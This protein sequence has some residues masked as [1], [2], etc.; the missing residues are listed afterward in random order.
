MDFIYFVMS[1]QETAVFGVPSNSSL[2]PRPLHHGLESR[3]FSMYKL[4]ITIVKTSSIFNSFTAP[5][6]LRQIFSLTL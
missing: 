6:S 4:E 1:G 5:L 2:H 3:R